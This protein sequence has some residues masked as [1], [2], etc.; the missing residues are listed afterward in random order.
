MDSDVVR[1]T[2]VPLC[3]RSSN[4]VTTGLDRSAGGVA[5]AG[6]ARERVVALDRNPNVDHRRIKLQPH[7]ERVSVAG[8]VVVHD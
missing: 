6:L 3:G 8:A 2:G 7:N 1:P 5:G 4:A